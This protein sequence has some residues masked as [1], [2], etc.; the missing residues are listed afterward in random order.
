VI[1]QLRSE[2]LKQRSTETTLLLFLVMFG[3]VAFAVATHVLALTADQLS[4]RSHQLGV[5]Q[6]GTRAGMLF[7]ALAGAIAFT[8][9]IRYGTIRPTFLVTPRRGPVVAAK[10]AVS[11]AAG[12]AFGLLA[13]ALMVAFA[14]IAFAARG[15]DNQFTAGDYL[16]LLLGGSVAAAMWAAIGLGVG[17][18]VRDQVAAIIG[19][20]VW[21]LLVEGTSESFVP[22][23][24]RLLPGEAGLALASN[25][26]RPPAAVAALL[27]I[28]YAAAI[29]AAGWVVTLRRDVA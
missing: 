19:L 22:G 1:A 6:V 7:A 9:E 12:A 27:L 2:L 4:S 25:I 13:Q 5:F 11:G 24:G 28:F 16:Q 8:A 15:I 20:C 23:F 21:I 3:L 17:A 18:L 10:L 26:D 14:T 29:S